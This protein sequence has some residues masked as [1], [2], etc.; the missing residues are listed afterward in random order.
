MREYKEGK[1]EK[2]GKV[3]LSLSPP[4][5]SSP[6]GPS[7]SAVG[8]DAHHRRRPDPRSGLQGSGRTLS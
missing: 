4:D 2:K 3:P 5:L 8:E 1:K 6:A 7:V